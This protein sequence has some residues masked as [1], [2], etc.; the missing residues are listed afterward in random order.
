MA[1]VDQNFIGEAFPAAGI[2]SGF[3]QQEPQL[4]PAKTVLGNVEEGVAEIKALLQRFDEINAKFARGP[5]RRGDGQGA[6]GAG[7]SVQDRIE[8]ASAWELD[9]R[10]ELA[11]DA[12]RCRRPMRT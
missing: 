12:L 8:A 9:S 11:M 3:L 6:R 5:V 10:L 1:G 4:D 2:R 7:A